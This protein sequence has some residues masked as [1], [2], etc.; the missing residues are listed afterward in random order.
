MGLFNKKGFSPKKEKP[1]ASSS[2][3]AAAD[4]LKKFFEKK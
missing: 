4:A 2:Q 1:K 3:E